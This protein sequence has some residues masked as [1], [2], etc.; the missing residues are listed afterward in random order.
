LDIMMDQRSPVLRHV[1]SGDGP[2]PTLAD[3]LLIDAED[4]P[5]PVAPP[6]HP[7]L[8]AAAL[9]LV[10]VNLR[11]A[12]SSTAP[13]LAELVRDTGVS[14]TLAS[15]LTTAPVLCLGLFGLVAP[16]LARRFGTERLIL[17]M[18][19]VLAAGIGL[20]IVPAFVTQILASIVAGAGIG[21]IGTL[22]PGLVKRDFPNNPALITGVYTM[23]LCAG[24]AVAAGATVP[25][26]HVFGEAWAPALAFWAI[27]A[28]AAAVAWLPM[29]PRSHHAA[30]AAPP[31]MRGLWRD[32]LAW[33]VTIFMGLQSSLAYIV[34]AW[35]AVILRDRGVAPVTAGLVVACSILVQVA[36]ALGAPVLAARY[37][38]QSGAV[39][40]VLTLSVIGMMGCMFA[41]VG[42]LW[43][44]AVLLGIG[45]GGCFAIALTLIVLRSGDAHVAAQLSGMAQS[46]GYTLAAGGP[47]AFGL[48]HDRAGSWTV[49]AGLFVAIAV[50]AMLAGI[51][52][53]LDRRV[54]AGRL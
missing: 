49:T 23:A 11:P 37:R 27:P 4:E 8:L 47:L 44:W 9:V 18:L 42:T 24:A 40:A 16:G 1:E 36:A 32:R 20:R 15:V 17:A 31:A 3:E 19:L 13:V 12:L 48:L 28:V 29:V 51:P 22:L 30:H 2:S 25:L 39:V 14:A 54:L 21:V 35:L 34:F 45:Q 53:G 26:T 33:Q 38:Q 46:V 10:A 7:L 50:G 6:R 5:G 52:A 43:G 41:P